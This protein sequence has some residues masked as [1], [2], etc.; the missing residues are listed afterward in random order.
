MTALSQLGE[1]A[2]RGLGRRATAD[3]LW[4]Q[5]RIVLACTTQGRD[6][7]LVALELLAPTRNKRRSAHVGADTLM[8]FLSL[9]ET[10]SFA[11]LLTRVLSDG[12]QSLERQRK[13]R[14]ESSD[15]PESPKAKPR[16]TVANFTSSTSV[17]DRSRLLISALLVRG[18]S[19]T[20]CSLPLLVAKREWRILSRL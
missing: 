19:S 2:D 1:K 4:D 14:F 12:G 10:G 15:R 16:S 8:S 17:S 3:V 6:G 11:L 7:I 20:D 13:F 5:V 9:S 18:G